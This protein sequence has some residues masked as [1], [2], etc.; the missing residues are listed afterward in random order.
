MKKLIGLVL[1]WLFAYSST[2]NS[3]IINITS[4]YNPTG[5][6]IISVTDTDDSWDY[7][8]TIFLTSDSYLNVGEFPIFTSI[9]SSPSGGDLFF[10]LNGSP[11]GPYSDVEDTNDNER[12]IA[13]V[14]NLDLSLPLAGWH[15]GR[16][17]GEPRE[18]IRFTYNIPSN[19]PS[20]VPEPSTLLLM[21]V[22]M[23]GLGATRLRKKI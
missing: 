9:D 11:L 3:A 23:I 22:G 15:F 17:A 13:T 8:G 19:N 5:N 10:N 4:A 20:S 12:I 2:A 16:T 6:L 21:S 1:V 7:L 14:T 18:E